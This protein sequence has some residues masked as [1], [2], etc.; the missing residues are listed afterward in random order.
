MPLRDADTSKC[1]PDCQQ[2]R[3]GF[4]GGI[5]TTL[6]AAAPPAQPVESQHSEPAEYAHERAHSH[7]LGREI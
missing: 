7:H 2:R 5:M 6:R 1:H 3:Q 4:R